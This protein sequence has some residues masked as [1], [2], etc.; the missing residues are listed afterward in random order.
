MTATTGSTFSVIVRAVDA[1]RIPTTM[2]RFAADRGLLS[3]VLANPTTPDD[4][5]DELVDAVV[6]GT[7]HL[8]ADDAAELLERR[9]GRAGD[10][11]GADRRVVVAATALRHAADLDHDTL[12]AALSRVS[13][14]DDAYEVLCD[15]RVDTA[16]LPVAAGEQFTHLGD[17]ARLAWLAVAT[18]AHVDD[19]EAADALARVD[20][21]ANPRR[22]IA[23]LIRDALDARPH[24]VERLASRD[25]TADITRTAVAG[26]HH[27]RLVDHAWLLAGTPE[28]ARFAALAALA[29][30]F[31]DHAVADEAE[32]RLPGDEDVDDAVRR[33]RRF[34]PAHA[35]R[36]PAQLR[37]PAHDHTHTP[38]DEALRWATRNSEGKRA[39]TLVAFLANPHL[40]S[41]HR[42][43]VV[44]AL[45]SGGFRRPHRDRLA[46]LDDD[47]ARTLVDE[48]DRRRHAR[49][50]RQ[51]DATWTARDVDPRAD[52]HVTSTSGVA[53][54]IR[55]LGDDP[56]RWRSYQ[57]LLDDGGFTTPAA[58]DV[59]DLAAAL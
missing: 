12:T 52:V 18:P 7:L 9:P 16:A 1:A 19:T 58:G 39:G 11:L 5:L 53:Y 10:L 28:S 4:L 36:A 3:A 59:V 21:W 14:P 13:K 2:R 43:S 24:L 8:S 17:I 23:A 29:N 48:W 49:A 51:A 22:G 27:A 57:R 54:A 44:A 55:A 35:D 33:R 34:F 42:D 6:A 20:S 46:G 50:P 41:H 30:P 45:S 56:D 26:S 47:D 32:R 25:D 38:L 15:P 31:A 37:N 40:D